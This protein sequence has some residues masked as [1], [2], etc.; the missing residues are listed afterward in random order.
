M[1]VL[2]TRRRALISNGK[3]YIVKGSAGSTVEYIL[4]KDGRLVFTG[5]GTIPSDDCPPV[6]YW[7]DVK[8]IEFGEGITNINNDYY[9]RSHEL[10][11]VEYVKLPSTIRAL[12]DFM[13][14]NNGI[15]SQVSI[16]YA[17]SVEEYLGLS[18]VFIKAFAIDETVR[19]DANYY[20]NDTLLENFVASQGITTIKNSCFYR[21]GTLVS[22]DLDGVTEIGSSAFSRAINLASLNTPDVTTVGSYAFLNCS[23]LRRIALPKV[24]SIGDQAFFGMKGTQFD[25]SDCLGIPTAGTDVFRGVSGSWKIIVPDNLYDDWKVAPGW[26]GY[27]S[28]IVKASEVT[29]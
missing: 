19:I 1:S 20:F 6:E 2:S 3:N 12:S 10:G 13:L 8:A 21:S 17:M 22:A 25:F 15:S 5:T 23:S 27:A 18:S 26:S 7:Q 29:T 4:Y 9:D 14:R 11:G 28:Y 24:T 16:Y